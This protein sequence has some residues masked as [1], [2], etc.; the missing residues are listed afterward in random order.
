MN[1]YLKFAAVFFLAANLHAQSPSWRIRNDGTL[2]R[3]DV[4]YFSLGFYFTEYAF[5]KEERLTAMRAIADGGFNTMLTGIP[6]RT[7]S[8]D[9][10]LVWDTNAYEALIDEGATRGLQFFGW[11]MGN[12]DFPTGAKPLEVVNRFK[13]KSNVLGWAI[14]DDT[15]WVDSG[16]GYYTPA[17]LGAKRNQILSADPSR[18]V[19][20]SFS[21]YFANLTASEKRDYLSNTDFGSL[22]QYPLFTDATEIDTAFRN[23]D[24]ASK[25]ALPKSHVGVSAQSFKWAGP[26]NRM[27]TVAE[28]RCLAYL[29]LLGGAK[30]ILWYAYAD[31]DNPPLSNAHP[32]IWNELKNIR[33]DLIGSG[34][35]GNVMLD[36]ERKTDLVTNGTS[37]RASSWV[38]GS[39]VYLVGANHSSQFYQYAHLPL[40]QSVTGSPQQIVT[41]LG[42][43][44]DP[45]YPDGLGQ[46]G[47]AANVFSMLLPP[48]GVKAYKLTL[49]AYLKNPGFESGKLNWSVSSTNSAHNDASFVTGNFANKDGALHGAHWKASDYTVY[50]YQKMTGLPN[51]NYTVRAWTRSSGGQTKAT[52]VAKGYNSAGTKRESAISPSDLWETVKLTD[53]AVSNGRCEIGFFSAARANQWLNFDAVEFWRQPN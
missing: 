31:E 34:G 53:I 44:N 43:L 37:V 49:S 3:D 11:C 23:I 45:T 2:V 16:T 30:S 19:W 13:G 21:G 42:V 1:D 36:G 47:N 48:L 26:E 29:P 18:P 39:S 17:G 24:E 33:D 7:S 46:T 28:T 51:G 10:T 14:A 32:A 9:S 4:P 15:D 25:F 41:R 12:D 6:H 22:Q 52:L 38:L 40:P 27:P 35:L 8:V 20:S 50:T 5:T